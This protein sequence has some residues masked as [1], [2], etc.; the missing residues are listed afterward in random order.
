VQ[1]S[2]SSRSSQLQPSHLQHRS[3]GQG[4]FAQTAK[5]TVPELGRNL[6]NRAWEQVVKDWEHPDPSRSLFVAMKN[7]DSTFFRSRAEEVKF[8]QRQIVA[9]E[10]INV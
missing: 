1:I 10:F 7:W 9:L 2:P 6:R 8:G 5:H 3:G 4:N